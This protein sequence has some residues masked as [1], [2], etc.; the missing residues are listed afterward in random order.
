[1]LFSIHLCLMQWNFSNG[2][3]YGNGYDWPIVNWN[4]N[5][6]N[7][8]NGNNI[9]TEIKTFKTYRN[10]NVCIGNGKKTQIIRCAVEVSMNHTL[11]HAHSISNC[12]LWA[13][14]FEHTRVNLYHCI[15]FLVF[16]SKFSLR[17]CSVTLSNSK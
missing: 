10:G 1:M 15:I 13:H 7:F 2:N 5:D 6:G 9:K 12:I 4:G 11:K 8:Q 14:A 17:F 3:D 16:I